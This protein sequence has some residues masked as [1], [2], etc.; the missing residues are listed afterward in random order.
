MLKRLQLKKRYQ[1]NIA[2]R[3][4]SIATIFLMVVQLI[5]S[6]IQNKRLYNQELER[7]RKKIETDANFLSIVAHNSLLGRCNRAGP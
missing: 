3:Y 2:F 5:I 7:I 1:N 6:G 4:L